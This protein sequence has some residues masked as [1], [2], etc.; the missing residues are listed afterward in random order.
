MKE[1][2]TTPCLCARPE[3]KKKT[4]RTNSSKLRGGFIEPQDY[5][6]L[7][8]NMAWTNTEMITQYLNEKSLEG[9]TLDQ[10]AYDVSSKKPYHYI[11]K[12]R[13]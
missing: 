7:C 10:F 11:F 6:Y 3:K 13:V 8:D 9:W 4:I 12:R 5:E 1:K 2:R